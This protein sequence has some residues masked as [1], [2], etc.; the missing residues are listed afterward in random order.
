MTD[1]KKKG[2][3]VYALGILTVL[4]CVGAAVA[5][6][7]NKNCSAKGGDWNWFVCSMPRQGVTIK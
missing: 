2:L 4:L 7:Q 3:Q 6:V 5:H 1:D